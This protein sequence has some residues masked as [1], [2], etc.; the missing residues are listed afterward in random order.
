MARTYAQ[1]SA[2]ISQKLQ[3]TGVAEFVAAEINN[4]LEDTISEV[5]RAYLHIVEV[6]FEIE[7]RFGSASSTSAN[8]LVDSAKTQFLSTDT[9]KNLFNDNDKTYAVITSFS[10]S[11]Q[12]GLS[13]DIFTVG[14]AYYV[15]NRRCQNSRQFYIGGMFDNDQ[16]IRAEYPVNTLPFSGIRHWRNVIKINEEVAEVDFD[17]TPDDS[18]ASQTASFTRVL[19]QVAKPHILCQLTDLAGA[20]HT[21]ATVGA[22]S[23][24]VKSLTDAEVVEAGD[25]FHIAGHSATYVVTADLTLANQA[26]T[27]SSLAFWPALEAG[28]AADVVISFTSS[29]LTPAIEDL[30]IR[31]CFARLVRFHG[32]KFLTRIPFGGANVFG[33]FRQLGRDIWDETEKDLNKAEPQT[34]KVY[35]KGGHFGHHRGIHIGGHG[36]GHG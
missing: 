15:Y 31:R 5:S 34:K 35:S 11:S 29:T 10:S 23:M 33:N 7:S 26:S 36:H 3:D 8:N 13:A 12:V 28:A 4:E 27:G 25:E 19:F 18:D 1:V 16:I 20:V 2:A 21:T 14:E 30:V 24:Q 32:A 17:F 6:P 9:D 22:I